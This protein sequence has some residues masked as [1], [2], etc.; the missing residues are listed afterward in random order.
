M[1]KVH[2]CVKFENKLVQSEWNL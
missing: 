1:Q 2:E